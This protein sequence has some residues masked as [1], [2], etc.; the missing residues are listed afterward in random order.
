MI[1]VNSRLDIVKPDNVKK[2]I[3]IFTGNSYVR[4]DGALVQGRG[5]AKFVRDTY[6]GIDLVFGEMIAAKCGHLG[7]YGLLWTEYAGFVIGVAQVKYNY[8]D[9]ADIDLI[10]R[11]VEKLDRLARHRLKNVFHINYP[12]IGNG[13]LSVSDVEPLLNVLPDNV[14]VYKV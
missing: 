1:L 6:K 5:I 9:H 7:E 2:D 3:F 14:L 10:K 4:K 11:T 13:Q 12:G 8:S